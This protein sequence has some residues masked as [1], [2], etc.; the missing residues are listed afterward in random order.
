M[1]FVQNVPAISI[2]S[3]MLGAIVTSVVSRTAARRLSLALVTV[4][5]GL[6]A[7]LLGYLMQT[8]TSYVYSMGHWPAPWGNELR[9]G[10][11]EAGLALLFCLITLA[12]LLGGAREAQEDIKKD[13]RHYFYIMV[14][15]LLAANLALVYTNDLFT[16]YVF[17]EI[18]TIT[19][20]GMILGR[21][22]DFTNMAALRYMIMSLMGSGLL[23]MG[24]CFLYDMTGNLLMS[25]IQEEVAVLAATGEYRVPLLLSIGLICVGLAIKSALW[26]FHSWLPGAYGR[27]TTTAQCMLSS[28]VSKGYIF[29]M[30]KIVFRVVGLDV[31]VDSRIINV[32]FILGIIGMIIGSWDAIHQNNIRRMIAYSSVAQIGYIYMGIGMGTMGGIV[33][34]IY[35]IFTHAAAKCLVFVSAAGLCREA[36]HKSDMRSLAGTGLHYKIAGVGFVVGSLSMIGI[37]GLG[38]F[39]SKFLFAQASLELS[40]FTYVPVL[41]ALAVSTVLNAIYFMRT[42][43]WIYTPKVKAPDLPAP[44][45]AETKK[46]REAKGLLHTG[47][48]GDRGPEWHHELEDAGM[49]TVQ[50]DLAIVLLVVLNIFM[51]VAVAFMLQLIQ[52]GLAVFG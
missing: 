1:S 30:L 7:W 5:T 26:P 50:Y 46:E 49:T 27:S 22:D 52:G 36:G 13:K 24:I 47:D 35:H 38:G 42:V 45:D 11:L 44:A 29:L 12:A 10:A 41:G 3:I 51:G 4:N 6:S 18:S 43:L 23:L 33:A 39:A 25:N 19:A 15:L 32:F 17:V 8:G 31:F 14:D 2:L 37:P 9:A 40:A 21:F 28:I 48:T 20:C 16:A 34:A